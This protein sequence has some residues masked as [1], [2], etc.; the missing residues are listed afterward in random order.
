MNSIAQQAVPNGMG[1]RELARDQFTALS[2]PVTFNTHF[3]SS[4]KRVV[5]QF[6]LPETS[7]VS[8]T[9]FITPT[10]SRKDVERDTVEGHRPGT[11]S[12]FLLDAFPRRHA[13]DV[14]IPF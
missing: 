11:Q 7:L 4:S 13:L 9:R 10:S 5:S 2:A 8:I 14:L 1:H 12:T 3:V 6:G